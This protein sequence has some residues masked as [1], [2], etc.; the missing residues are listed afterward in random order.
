MQKLKR[1]YNLAPWFRTRTL[2]ALEVIIFPNNSALKLQILRITV[3]GYHLEEPKAKES[4]PAYTKL[5]EP[6][7]QGKKDKKK[8]TRKRRWDN[9][10][11]QEKPI[12]A[13]SNNIINASKKK[14][15]KHNVNEFKYSNY[16]K[17]SYY[18]SICTKSLEN[19]Y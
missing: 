8:R 6:V 15:K 3:K 1:T 13:T 7:K 19:L 16:N 12:L 17:K 18:V 10:R 2:V 14:K 4:I 11:K 9:I 5:A